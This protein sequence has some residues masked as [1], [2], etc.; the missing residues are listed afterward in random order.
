M[1]LSLV[2]PFLTMEQYIIPHCSAEEIIDQVYNIRRYLPGGMITMQ[3]TEM[4]PTRMCRV[5]FVRRSK[6]IV[7]QL[8]VCTALTNDVKV[9]RAFRDARNGSFPDNVNITNRKYD[10]NVENFKEFFALNQ[11]SEES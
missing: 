11:E 9:L 10:F 3:V 1:F 8:Y 5:V 4:P 6:S 2:K 7:D